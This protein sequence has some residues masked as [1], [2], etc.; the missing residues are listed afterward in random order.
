MLHFLN[1]VRYNSVMDTT[2][3][4]QLPNE[5]TLKLVFELWDDIASSTTPIELSDRAMAEIQRRPQ[6]LVVDPSISI[7]D[8]EL[9]RRVNG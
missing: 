6:D 8:E 2:T 4:H 9:W 3:L 7:D 1:I 5:V